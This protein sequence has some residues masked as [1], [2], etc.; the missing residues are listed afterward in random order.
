MPSPTTLQSANAPESESQDSVLAPEEDRTPQASRH[1]SASGLPDPA[2]TTS[3]TI[4]VA[5]SD[6]VEA[7]SALATSGATPASMPRNPALASTA[8]VHD[9]S[10]ESP[11]MNETLSVIQEHITNMS[12]PGHSGSGDRQGTNDSSSEY[13]MSYI[14][15]EET[16][17]EESSHG[18]EEVAVW[19]ADQVADYL[20]SVG[21]EQKHCEYFREQEITGDVLLAMDQ[22]TILH[23]QFDIGP[24]GRRLKMWTKIKALQNKVRGFSPKGTRRSTRNYGSEVGSKSSGRLRS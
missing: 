11:V 5:P 13:S 3:P 12:M 7:T 2:N 6:D 22:D 4:T 1:V 18:E 14:N 24:V 20:S 21:V 19:T 8:N 15:G 10:R 23:P 9:H 16:D 17:E